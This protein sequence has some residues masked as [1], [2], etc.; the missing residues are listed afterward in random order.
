MAMH[1]QNMFRKTPILHHLQ[2]TLSST[3]NPPLTRQLCRGSTTWYQTEKAKPRR[4]VIRR[5]RVGV[6]TGGR[7]MFSAGDFLG[8]YRP[9]AGFAAAKIV[10]LAFKV[11]VIPA[12]AIL[13]VCCSMTWETTILRTLFHT[14]KHTLHELPFDRS[15]PFCRTHRCSRFHDQLR[16]RHLLRDMLHVGTPLERWMLLTRHPRIPSPWCTPTS[17]RHERWTL[18]TAIWRHL[19]RPLSKHG[20]LLE[21]SFHLESPLWHHLPSS[22]TKPKRKQRL[23]ESTSF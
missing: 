19:G 4:D 22:T 2:S 15:L 16:L 20:C 18:I 6:N 5:S 9:Q 3:N 14:T 12:F 11:V 10:V 21:A 1:M 23:I 13:T 7:A 8:L 17:A